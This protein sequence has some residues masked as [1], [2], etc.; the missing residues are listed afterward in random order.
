MKD[1]IIIYHGDCPD[2]FGGA[3]AAHKKFGD[4][5]EYI[6]VNH[7]APPPAGL[8][9]KEIYM[10]DFTYPIEIMRDLLARNKRI[11]AIDHHV[12]REESVKLT[13]DYS[14]AVDHSGSVLAW[15]YFHKDEPVPLLLKYVEDGDLFKYV[16]PDSRAI[17]IY[18]DSFDYDFSLWNQLA[19]DADNTEKIKEFIEKGNLMLNYQDELLKRIVEESAIKVEF[20]GHQVLAVNAPHEFSSRIGEML[21][22]KMPPMAII[23]S[24]LK[25]GVHV[26]LRG[27]GSI[28]VSKM[29]EKFGGGGHKSSAGFG[30]PAISTFPWKE[31][32]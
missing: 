10:V 21:Y 30:L 11:T 7:D 24:E 28:D 29:A 25:N 5:A 9:N 22:T 27:N 3:W 1:I 19:K 13:Q 17:T 23:W 14:Y 12:T 18:I 16:L 2:G 8:D 26:S 4:K 32:K 15:Q 31:K 20:E 6:G